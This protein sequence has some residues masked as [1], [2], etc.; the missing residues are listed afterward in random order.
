MRL[1]WTRHRE[2]RAERERTE[3][4]LEQVLAQRPLVVKH[5]EAAERH[6]RANHI[7][8][9]VYSILDGRR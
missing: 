1:P 2:A 4:R 7:A 3:A 5:A 6:V 8:E 9:K